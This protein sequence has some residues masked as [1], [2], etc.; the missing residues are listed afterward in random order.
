LILEHRGCLLGVADLVRLTHRN[1]L[2]NRQRGLFHQL[3]RQMSVSVAQKR[4]HRTTRLIHRNYPPNRQGGLFHR[5]LRQMS[6]SVAQKRHHRTTRLIHRNY[7]LN[8]QGGLFHRLLRQMSVSVARKGCY[9]TPIRHQMIRLI[10]PNCQ[11]QV[12][13]GVNQ[14]DHCCPIRN[15]YRMIHP[16]GCWGHLI[17]LEPANVAHCLV[18][19][20]TIHLVHQGSRAENQ[21]SCCPT[22]HRKNH[23]GCLNCLT[24]QK[25]LVVSQINHLVYPNCLILQKAAMLD[26]CRY[27]RLFSQICHQEHPNR[28]Q[29]AAMPMISES[30]HRSRRCLHTQNHHLC[31]RH[32]RIF[33]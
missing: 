31:R 6:V 2:P 33:D 24:D 25:A 32:H 29:G 19:H 18:R 13:W 26:G 20:R 16:P 9:L 23:L 7:P 4:H 3:I 1:Y 21:I 11:E 10:H 12:R 28:W 14:R 17:R 30:D 27:R 22:H 5:L 15:H 8:R